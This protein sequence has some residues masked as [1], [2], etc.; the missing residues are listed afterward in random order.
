MAVSLETKL[1]ILQQSEYEW[2]RFRQWMQSHSDSQEHVSPKKWTTKLKILRFFAPVMGLHT[3]LLI[4]EVPKHLIISS[5]VLLATIK[6]RMLQ[7]QGLQVVAIAGSYGKT[8]TKYIAH[9]VLSGSKKVLM[10]PENINTPIG[11]ARVILSKLSSTHQVFLAELGEYYPGDISA[12]TRFLAP[13][14]KILT[15]VGYAH[16]ERF[17]TEEKLRKGLM[18][19]VT[20][21]P[22]KGEHFVFGKDYGDEHIQDVQVS[23]AG[24]EFNYF[25]ESYFIPLY[26]KHNA[27]NCLPTLWLASK[28]GITSST[29]KEK[30]SSLPFIPHRLEPT[31]LEHNILL[32]DNGYNANPGSSKETLE[33]IRVLEGSQKIIFTPGYVDMGDYQE[34]E[35][36]K[37]GENIAGIAD[38]CVVIDGVNSDAIARGLKHSHFPD[39][40]I[41][42]AKGE[43]EGMELISKKVKPSAVILFENSVPELYK[44]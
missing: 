4:L 29:V 44:A 31:Q 43:Q 41:I 10:T 23:R 2:P 18:E 26:G 27:L 5:T 16:L 33:V 25:G 13:D 1:A 30:L 37:L 3:T 21:M 17:G 6:L 35:N 7:R 9:H 15:P 36:E 12:L 32:L 11:I 40:K 42:H 22:N 38:I 14:Y 8:S 34:K 24:T 28:L 19:L 39:E 20:T